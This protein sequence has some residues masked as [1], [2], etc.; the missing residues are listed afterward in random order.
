MGAIAVYLYVLPQPHHEASDGFHRA[1]AFSLLALSPLFHAF[2]CRSPR[3]SILL[4]RPFVS[5]PLIGA[6]LLSAGVHL[7]AVAI[8]SLRPVFRTF[9]MSASQWLLVVG[10]SAAILPAFELAKGIWRMRTYFWKATISSLLLGLGV[11]ASS[12]I[13]RADGV[14]VHMSLVKPGE[15][16]VDGVTEEWPSAMTDLNKTVLGAAGPSLGMRAAL[17]YDETNLYVAAEI[18]DSRILR[19]RGCAEADDHAA[20]V[21]AFPRPS[22]GFAMH[23]ISLYP[24]EP[25]R[26]AG[27]VKHRGGSAIPGAKLVEAPKNAPGMMG[28][29]VAIP[30]RAFPEAATVRAGLRGALRY[31]DGDGRAARNILGTS[32]DVPA[33]DLP[34]LPMEAEQSLEAGLVKEKGLSAGPSHDRYADV[35]GDGM[36]E[37]IMVFGRYL[38]ILG[39]HYRNGTE[40]YF[41]DLVVDATTGG[42][43]LFEVRDVTGD[44]KADVIVRRRVGAGDGYREVAQ[45]FALGK[46]DTL[47]PVYQHEVGIHSPSGTISNELRFSSEGGKPTLIVGAGTVSGYSATTYR[48]PV[49]TSMEPLLLPWG[50]VKAQVYQ[51]SGRGFSKIREEKQ[52]PGKASG[53]SAVAAGGGRAPRREAPRLVA[54]SEAAKPPNPEELQDQVYALYKRDRRITKHDRPRFDLAVDLAE[55]ERK[56][57]LILHGRDLV[58]FGRGFKNG[59]GYAFM[60]L[61]QFADAADVLDVSARDLNHDG[62]AEILVRG[63]LHTMPPKEMGFDKGTV[64]ERELL[65]VYRVAPSGIG[66]VFGVETGRGIGTKHIQGALALVP[67]T[68]GIDPRGATRHRAG[69]DGADLPVPSGHDARRRDGAAASALGRGGGGAVPLGRRQLRA[70]AVAPPAWADGRHE[71]PRHQERQRRATAAAGDGSGGR[72][73]RRATAAGRTAPR[74]WWTLRAR[75]GALPNSAAARGGVVR[76]WRH[77]GTGLLRLGSGSL[78]ARVLGPPRP[79]MGL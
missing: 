57:R 59:A 54:L 26:S 78:P 71:S 45:V 30:W 3:S 23:E 47:E 51:W 33:A 52:S 44:G 64:V 15:I 37:R 17:T 13:A 41:A 28:L 32:T 24:G 65:L 5:W 62:K 21:I 56:E 25:G 1:M 35:A 10:L 55:D 11:V 12:G 36:Y 34:R 76:A 67:T 61:E 46:S 29:E 73:Q 22:G 70:R 39:P 4:H 31:Y 20:L 7:V 49:E 42:L 6:C 16:R 50:T 27:C 79:G 74:A 48:E 8:P 19:T 53:E 14:S 38:V 2:G 75:A 72:R 43:P 69:L 77:G 58:V 68:S 63:V 40:Y 9:P 60:T 18:K 66:R